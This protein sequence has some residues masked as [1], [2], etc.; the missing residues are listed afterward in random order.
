MTRLSDGLVRKNLTSHLGD[1]QSLLDIWTG[2]QF[3]GEYSTLLEGPVV[4]IEWKTYEGWPLPAK[5]HWCLHRLSLLAYLCKT[6]SI[7]PNK[8][9]AQLNAKSVT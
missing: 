2:S 7:K 5:G 3:T 8:D 6:R 1:K 4:C 9:K